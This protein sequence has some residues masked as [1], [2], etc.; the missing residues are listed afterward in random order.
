MLEIDVAVTI[1]NLSITLTSLCTCATDIP[2][3]KRAVARTTANAPIGELYHTRDVARV[4]RQGHD[5]R[6]LVD[7]PKHDCTISTATAQ[8]AYLYVHGGHNIIF[9]RLLVF[10]GM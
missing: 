9:M 10:M 3:H 5:S 6:Y 2:N 7:V 4:S 8:A 1:D